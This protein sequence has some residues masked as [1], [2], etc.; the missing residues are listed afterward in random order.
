MNCI[1]A[2][3]FPTRFV[4]VAATDLLLSGRHQWESDGVRVDTGY[5]N[6]LPGEPD[7]QGWNC[8]IKDYSQ[9]GKLIDKGCSATMYTICETRDP[10]PSYS[11]N[12][13]AAYFS[14]RVLIS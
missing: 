11:F 5:T 1:I 10:V 8:I 9:D 4:W 6:W 12:C 3:C 7:T 13:E 2:A 14:L